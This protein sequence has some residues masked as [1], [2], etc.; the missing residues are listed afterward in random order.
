MKTSDVLAEARHGFACA[1]CFADALRHIERDL[2]DLAFLDQ[3]ARGVACGKSGIF[4]FGIEETND[5]VSPFGLPT[6]S[7]RHVNFGFVT[8][9]THE[10]FD[11]RAQ[12]IGINIAFTVGC[13]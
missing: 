5:L 13:V 1:G 4:R 8:P 11:G 2:A 3:D 9:D 10:L 12:D 6:P 7:M